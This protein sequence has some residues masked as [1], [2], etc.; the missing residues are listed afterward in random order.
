[1]RP[2]NPAKF[3]VFFPVSREFG[4][5]EVRMSLRPP[6]SSLRLF[7]CSACC[8]ESSQIWAKIAN[9]SSSRSA[10]FLS[11]G[12]EIPIRSHFSP[13]TNARCPSNKESA[14]S[15]RIDRALP[16]SLRKRFLH[17]SEQPPTLPCFLC[18]RCCGELGPNQRLVKRLGGKSSSEVEPSSPV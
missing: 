14:P 13:P 11:Q 5:R 9:F 10:H 17:C 1:M 15:V 3:P 12:P 7:L 4:R 6:P 16:S 18:S 2:G 8:G